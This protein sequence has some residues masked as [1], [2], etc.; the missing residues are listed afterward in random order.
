MCINSHHD[1]WG[2]CGRCGAYLVINSSTGLCYYCEQGQI[3]Y[4]YPQQ[5]DYEC[6][7]CHGKFNQPAMPPTVS[8]SICYKCPFCG[9][10][11]E[12]M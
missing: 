1:Y 2:F 9:R 12:G 8:S 5:F 6:P 11:M 3:T 10:I 4:S 7:D